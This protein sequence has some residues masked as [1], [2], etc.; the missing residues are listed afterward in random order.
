MNIFVRK[1]A[2]WIL[3][4]WGAALPAPAFAATINVVPDGVAG[5]PL[6][7]AIQAA[8]T[9]DAVSPC[10]TG[11]GT[12]TLVLL[13]YD[14]NPNFSL[15]SNAGSD[16]D[17][18]ATGDLDVSSAIIIQGANPWQTVIVGPQFDRAI[19]VRPSGSLTLNDVTVIG[20]SIVGS[21]AN[22]GGVVRK[23]ANATL[24][25]N[26]SVLRGGNADLG[27]AVYAQGAGVL[28]LEKVS[29]FDNQAGFGG[30]IALQQTSGVESILNNVTISANNANFSGG[31]VY[32]SS[33]FRLRNATVARNRSAGAGGIHY[34]GVVNTTGVNLANSLLIDNI[35]GNGDASDIYCAGTTGNNQLG[36]RSY[37]LIGAVSNCTFASFSGIPDSSDARIS[38]LFDFGSG[39]PTHALLSGS[40]A[41]GAGNPSNSNPL[42]ACLG[43]DAR[44]I[45]RSPPCDLGA[46]EERFDVTVNSFSDFPDL[47]P[48]D[49]V[50]QAQGNVC[51]LRAVA[52][53][54][55]ASRG[56]WFVKLPVGTYSVSRAFNSGNDEDGGDLDVKLIL[57]DPTPFHMTLFGMGDADDVQIVG[58]GSDRVLE[59]RAR[60]YSGPPQFDFVHFPL[61]FALLN[62]TVSGGE[63]NIDPFQDDPNAQLEGGGIKVTGG[64]SLFYN[65]IVKDNYVES[66]PATED[67]RGGG[68]H[69]DVRTSPNNQVTEFFATSAHLERFAVVDNATGDE[70]GGHSKFAG[71]IYAAGE[72][73]FGVGLSD[74][75]TMTNGVVAGNHSRAGGG[76]MT[77]GAVAA[78]FLSVVN[79]TAGPLQPP[80]FTQYAGGLTLGG[81][82]NSLRN[83]LISGNLAGS[84]SSDCETYE[85][86][87]SLVSLGY[88]LIATAGVSCVISGDT[89]TNLLNVNPQLGARTLSAGMP[90]YLPS[91]TGPAT[92]AIP[93]SLCSNGGGFGVHSDVRGVQR[94][95]NGNAHCDIG[96]VETELPLF[97][98][99]FE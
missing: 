85:S 87:S 17:A 53:E 74:S 19:D 60:R 6:R 90:I 31:G 82:N 11:A 39:L 81:Q 38:P 52:M 13:Q 95:G 8:N 57:N 30:G 62:A 96:A 36:A 77:F 64:K 78:S 88:N 84:V 48:G 3:L 32:A 93:L 75:I 10:P 34:A 21:T 25:I 65:V 47:N 70:G 94:P 20:G 67:S 43:S 49:G 99:G 72:P 76:V 5:C 41:L 46:Y 92:N 79:N 15:S 24:T 97:A 7:K 33:W 66:L 59:V 98:N 2:G 83:V 1:A 23:T 55:S 69:I 61:A 12:D 63:L 18:N 16:E 51:T 42:T 58:G 14:G 80:G 9:D 86:G 26:R 35:N 40:A 68:M 37:T 44:G 45:S 29:I 28:T 50:C 89:S 27:G 4:G 22:D 56:R 71:G 73:P 91:A 54:G